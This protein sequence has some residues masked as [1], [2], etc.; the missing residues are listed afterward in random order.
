MGVLVISVPLKVTIPLTVSEGL[1]NKGAIKSTV[2]PSTIAT[3]I[4]ATFKGTVKMN[5]GN[6]EEITCV[7]V[8]SSIANEIL[9]V[10]VRLGDWQSMAITFCHFVFLL[11]SRK[12]TLMTARP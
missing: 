6:G 4:K 8:D 12:L 11:S 1:I 10:C 2:G 7:N 3:A 5:D 9:V